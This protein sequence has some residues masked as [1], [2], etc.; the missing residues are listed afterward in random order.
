M[1]NND[2]YE[3]DINAEINNN[4]TDINTKNNDNIEDITSNNNSQDSINNTDDMNNT[5]SRDEYD[6]VDDFN[7][8]DVKAPVFGPFFKE[9]LGWVYSIG[10][11]LVATFIITQ[12]IIVNAAIPSQSM[13]STIMTGDRL[14]ANRVTYYI[15]SPK[16]F[17]VAVFKFPDD[18]KVLYIKRVIGL[19]GEQLEIR[20]NEV[21]IN[22]STEPLESSFINE[23]M[24]TND[25]IY[26]IP[27][28]GDKVADYLT[29]ITDT[30]KYDN[31][32]DGLFDEDCYFMLG[33]NRNYS[34]DSRMWNNKFV[35]ESYVQGKAEFRYFPF[36]QISLIKNKY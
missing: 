12:F 14:I 35:P 6:S 21:Y 23:P 15:N 28:A 31:D 1:S 13:E 10:L 19:P 3:N 36:N 24:L 11:A 33:D 27:K 16:R 4:E 2:E 32:G 34:A 26:N 8:T 17:E 29:F 30:N 25:A 5:K 20:E 7:T 18:P 9:L 22:G